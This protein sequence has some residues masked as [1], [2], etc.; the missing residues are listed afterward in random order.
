MTKTL[1]GLAP[2]LALTICVQTANGR[3]EVSHRN[4]AKVSIQQTSVYKRSARIDPL[5][6]SIQVQVKVIPQKRQ[7]YDTEGD[8]WW[9]DDVLEIRLSAEAGKDDP[10]YELLLLTHE[11]IEAILCRSR[12]I[13]NQ[14]VDAFD[15]S[16]KGS[17]EPGDDP[18][19]P[20]HFEHQSAEAAE[21]ALAQALRVNWRSY[22]SK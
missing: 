16:F 13:T 11:F 3:S 21:H 19:A 17:G 18:A 15:L 14:Q 1:G 4:N 5:A 10:R 20:Y 2:F 6:N 7:R 9:H 22:L 8:W 12:G